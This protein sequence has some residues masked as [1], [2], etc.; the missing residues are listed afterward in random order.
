MSRLPLVTKETANESQAKILENVEKS[1]G[2]V[3]NIL[4]TMVNSPAVAQAYSGFSHA[5]GKGTLPA[6][7]REQ[8]AIVVAET[9]SCNYCL[10]AHATLGKKSGLDDEQ[11]ES[12]RR[13]TASDSKVATALA[14][15]Q[16]LVEKRGHVSAQEV[17][18]LR[19]AG[20]SDGEVAEIVANVALNIFTNYFNHVADPEIDFPVVAALQQ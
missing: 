16:Q 2:G 7:V 3:P 20:Y 5:L 4:A 12:A 13:G 6:Q 17:E 14:F 15:A 18:E 10:A 19:S 1:M 8:I 9:N 11:V